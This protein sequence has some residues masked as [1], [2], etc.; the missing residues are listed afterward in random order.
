MP[1]VEIEITDEQAARAKE[2]ADYFKQTHDQFLRDVFKGG[3]EQAETLKELRDDPEP[4]FE[5]KP[6]ADPHEMD[7]DIPF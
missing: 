7:D 6:S 3:I 4:M 5:R 1:K 2:L